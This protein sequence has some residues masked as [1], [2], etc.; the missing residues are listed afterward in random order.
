MMVMSSVSAMTVILMMSMMSL[1]TLIFMIFSGTIALHVCDAQDVPMILMTLT[2]VMSM[3]V[4]DVCVHDD[5]GVSDDND[6]HANCIGDVHYVRNNLD[7][8]KRE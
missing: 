2:S 1:I 5:C 3:T 6:S 8:V 4:D 7:F